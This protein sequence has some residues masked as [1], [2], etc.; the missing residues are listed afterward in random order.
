MQKDIIS[1]EQLIEMMLEEDER[2]SRA[3]S[4][5]YDP[6]SGNLSPGTRFS[7]YIPE[8]EPSEI[9]I[10]VA[11]RE[12]P[13]VKMLLDGK[14]LTDAFPGSLENARQRW[15]E[16]RC[17]YDFPFWAF[18]CIKIKQKNGG[19]LD[20][21]F[22]L[23]APQRK[24]IREFEKMRE[25]EKPIRIVLVKAR[26]WGGSTATQIYMLWIQLM[27]KM[28]F[29]SLIVAHQNSGTDEVIAMAKTALDC[30]PRI[31]LSD[32]SDPMP[33]KEKVYV[34]A[35][36]SRCAIKIPRRNFRIKAGSAERPD[37]SR[38]GDYALV[39][40]TEVGLWRKTLGKSPSD[41][42]RA[43]TSGVL[44]HPET[45]IVMEST[46]N[47]VGTFFHK[48]YL[49]AKRGT[50][51]YHPVFVAWYEIEQYALAVDDRRA[52]A[53]RIVKNRRSD[54][55]DDNRVAT[56][57][58]IWNLW[59]A[60]ASLDAINWYEKCRGGT[61]NTDAMMSE[62]PS[63]DLEAFVSSGANVFNRSKALE[64]R[65]RCMPPRF[66]G[67]LMGRA[68]YGELA[69]EGIT[70]EPD[71]NGRLKIWDMPEVK[72]GQPVAMRD[73][74][75]TVVDVG[76][77][78]MKADWSVIAVFDRIRMMR[79]AGPAVAAQWRGH[80]DMDKLAWNA[81]RIARW[82]GDA[83]LVIESNTLETRDRDRYVDGDQSM[84]IL[85][86]LRE[87]YPN[88]YARRQSPEDIIEG[89][90]RKYGFHTNTATKPMIISNLVRVVREGLYI[91]RDEGCIDEYL[92]YERRP[93]GSYG[94]VAGKHD[95]MLMTRAIGLHI[96]FNE[97]TIP[98]T[99][100]GHT[101][102]GPLRRIAQ[103]SLF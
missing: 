39:H 47:G 50:S 92:T 61:D 74:Y 30:Y 49:A 38:G 37:S 76:G 72:N 75:V 86:Q 93:N 11:M 56:G 27:R 22:L 67:E 96:I 68:D 94:A 42:I 41:I 83:L 85:N 102:H 60:G 2:R 23:N 90:P 88:L 29:N 53:E 32:P 73:R 58:Y 99:P 101:C 14:S 103:P 44:L 20:I 63:N 59:E 89:R 26:Q 12:L 21:P 71:P 24:L 51:L 87:C 13:E 79:Q 91:E 9:R 66:S 28:G 54:F 82:Y 18:K 62:F 17:R 69:L 8:L 34:N 64:L 33:R 46:A 36:M 52:M 35:G 7:I 48:E 80:C 70:F 97:M 84:F 6:V 19:G 40:L 25:A 10:P 3:M 1:D 95:D 43:A 4:T 78:S 15:F 31:L 77:R 45:M 98:C 100:I 65:K 5:P 55:S 57:R 81:A 16:L